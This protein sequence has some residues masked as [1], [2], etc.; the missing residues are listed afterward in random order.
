MHRAVS[1]R[2]AGR[3]T[4]GIILVLLLLLFLPTAAL[5]SPTYY[6]DGATGLM[7]AGALD[8]DTGSEVVRHITNTRW[9]CRK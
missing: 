2:R 4:R 7:A 9:W 8:S 5:A 1:Y 6:V 3:F